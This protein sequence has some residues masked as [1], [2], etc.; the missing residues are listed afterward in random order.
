M[1]NKVIKIHMTAVFANNVNLWC[2]WH[3]LQLQLLPYWVPFFFSD[4]ASVNRGELGRLSFSFAG[5]N[6]C[7]INLHML[8]PIPIKGIL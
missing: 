7:N 5:K 1:K 8:L 3:L 6:D 4:K 2:K